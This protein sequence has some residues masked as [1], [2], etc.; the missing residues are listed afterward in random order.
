MGWLN[1]FN[2]QNASLEKYFTKLDK[3]YDEVIQQHLD[4]ERPKPEHEDLV[5]LLFQIQK[6]SCQGM[7]TLT[8]EQIKGVLTVCPLSLSTFIYVHMSVFLIYFSY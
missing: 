4:P 7:I 3:L 2:G 6:N 1:K 8:N 5:D